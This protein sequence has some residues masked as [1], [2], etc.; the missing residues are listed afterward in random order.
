MDH[1]GGIAKV[2]VR[3]EVAA[4][5]VVLSSSDEMVEFLTEKFKEKNHPKYYLK[6][7]D[8]KRLEIARASLRRTVFRGIDGSSQFQVI[9]FKPDSTS[10]R[11]AT[12]LC[13]CN[14]C[15]EDY[16]SCQLFSEHQLT[17]YNLN[18]VFLRSNNQTSTEDEIDLADEDEIYMNNFVTPE[19]YVAVAADKKSPDT[20]WFI[21]VIEADC[22]SATDEEDDYGNIIPKGATYFKGNFLER[23]NETIKLEVYKLSKKTTYFYKENILYPYVNFNETKKGLT[24][25]KRDL[26]DIIHFTEQTGF[27]HL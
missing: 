7:I 21:K 5:S 12:R 3:R 27:C 25:N 20:V 11:A 17:S 26:A 18:Q 4:G 1:V 22:E 24:L 16:G 10:I 13:L 19:S 9:V 14:L 2:A 15:K 6:E 23:V 8:S